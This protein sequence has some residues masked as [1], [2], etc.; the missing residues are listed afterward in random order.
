ME[1]FKEM[2][3]RDVSNVAVRCKGNDA[4]HPFAE[5]M[6]FF[7]LQDENGSSALMHGPFLVNTISQKSER[8]SFRQLGS[9]F[10]VGVTTQAAC[11]RRVRA[12]VF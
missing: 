8:S 12:G 4:R 11:A 10:R 9:A 1:H 6:P 2:N 3:A 5:H 7:V